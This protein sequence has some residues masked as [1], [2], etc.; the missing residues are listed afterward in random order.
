MDEP[1]ASTASDSNL[2]RL[3]E[4]LVPFVTTYITT[5]WDWRQGMTEPPVVRPGEDEPNA[6]PPGWIAE[7]AWTIVF[8]GAYPWAI[9]FS[10]ATLE[11]G[12]VRAYLDANALFVGC[13][14][15]YA[16]SVHRDA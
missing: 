8:E 6:R 16:I 12:P 2:Q 15:G 9:D 7:G 1:N 3:V 13:Y 14:A 5:E 11:E 10:A 4:G